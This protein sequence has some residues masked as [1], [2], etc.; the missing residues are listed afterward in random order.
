MSLTDDLA[1]LDEMRRNGALSEAEFQ[2]A[3]D[4]LLGGMPAGGPVL[5]ALNQLRRS[6]SDRWLAGVCGGLARSTGLESW[7]WRLIFSVLL[8]MGGMGIVAYLLLWI[9]V[10]EE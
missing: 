6:R 5:N 8:L 10:P 2:Q 3:K 4:R 7:G 9:F 1:R